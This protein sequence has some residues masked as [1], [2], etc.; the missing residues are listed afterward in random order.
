[1]NTIGRT[2]AYVALAGALL[3]TAITLDDRHYPAGA[4]ETGGRSLVV[5]GRDGELTRCKAIGVEDA[6]DAGCKALWQ[7][8]RRRFLQLGEPDR[9]RRVESVPATGDAKAE[10]LARGGEAQRSSQRWLSK[11]NSESLS[12]PVDSTG[13]RK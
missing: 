4:A 12:L 13:Q 11:S 6:D 7:A 8:N 1:M 10:A 2:I 9:D 3:A 5:S